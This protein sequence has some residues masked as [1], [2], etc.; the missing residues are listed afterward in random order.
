MGLQDRKLGLQDPIWSQGWRSCEVTHD[1]PPPFTFPACS[2]LST[3]RKLHPAFL[4]AVDGILYLFSGW[5]FL[6]FIGRRSFL[7]LGAC[8]LWVPYWSSHQ[9]APVVHLTDW[10]YPASGS[11][12]WHSL[13]VMDK[14]PKWENS[15]WAAVL[16]SLAGGF[17]ASSV[18]TTNTLVTWLR[19]SE[20]VSG[21]GEAVPSRLLASSIP[22]Q[23]VTTRVNMSFNR[24]V[25]ITVFI[26]GVKYTCH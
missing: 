2:S 18:H 8:F 1:R 13:Q 20:P 3:P 14:R 12:V 4:P 9:L 10:H 5:H 17:P 23:P 15:S 7:G 21:V 25:F 24:F 11:S 22:Y 6:N 19:P 16:S 26:I